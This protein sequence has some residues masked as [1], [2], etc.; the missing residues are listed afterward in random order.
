M[1]TGAPPFAFAAR[2]IAAIRAAE[3][4]RPDRLFDDPYAAALAGESG[5]AV[6]ERSERASGGENQFVPV[7]VRWF[8]EVLVG[9]VGGGR[10][11]VVLLGAGMDT[12]AYR[13]PLP[14]DAVVF[15]VDDAALLEEKDAVLRGL[16][17]RPRCR[18]IVVPDDLR[19]S[20]PDTLLGAGFAVGA[21]AVWL[22]EGLLFYLAEED[23]LSLLACAGALS[24]P[25][26]LLVVDVFGTGV[27][28]VPAMAPYLDWLE[29]SGLP[30]PFGTDDPA[31]LLAGCG[32]SV[33]LSTS[34]GAPDVSHGRLPA[35]ATARPASSTDRAYLVVARRG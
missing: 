24:A 8:D 6:R 21:P 26:S 16:E 2:W 27:R 22:A 33:E 34:P 15:E 29:R 23:V 32:W 13:L 20:W 1:S 25:G 4:A 14:A 3:S 19:G 28:A 7:R 17:A 11:Q 9:A 12:R 5:V 35:G 10:R 30:P 31:E 18:R